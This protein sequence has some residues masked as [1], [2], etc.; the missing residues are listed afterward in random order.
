MNQFTLTIPRLYADHHVAKVRQVLLPMNG[1]ENVVA[2]VAFKQVTIDFDPEKTSP[3]S[4][5]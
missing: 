5:P 2:S 4:D 3:R 1:V